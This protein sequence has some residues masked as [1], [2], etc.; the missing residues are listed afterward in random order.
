VD[1]D[2]PDIDGIDLVKSLRVSTRTPVIVLSARSAESDKVTALD[3]G[4]DDYIAKPFD[5][6]EFLARIRAALRRTCGTGGGS[7]IRIGI[8]IVDTA[9][10]TVT[11]P[12]GQVDLTPT[13]WKVLEVL[14]RNPGRLV[15]AAEVLASVP[16]RALVPGSSYLR[17]HLMHLRQKLETDPAAPRHLLTKPGRGFRFS[18]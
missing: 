17:G 6:A 5:E 12:L 1:L 3:A 8:W 15:S 7:R 2:L 16:G 13:E 14:V 9:S 4:A 11:G 18:P 10:R